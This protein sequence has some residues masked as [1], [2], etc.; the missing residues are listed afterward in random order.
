MALSEDTKER[1]VRLVDITKTI[2]HY[3]WV[4]FVIYVGF[5]SSQPRPNLLKILS[6]LS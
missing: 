2:V 4:P 5:M 1:I 3:G 6:P